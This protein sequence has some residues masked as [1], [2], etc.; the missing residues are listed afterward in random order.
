[1]PTPMYIPGDLLTP[2]EADMTATIVGWE[3]GNEE[4][5][6]NIEIY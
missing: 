4:N 3:N 6:E 5:G 2:I 1:M